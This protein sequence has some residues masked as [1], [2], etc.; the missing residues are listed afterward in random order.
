[1]NQLTP[2]VS[3][4]QAA[5]LLGGARPAFVAVHDRNRVQAARGPGSPPLFEVA[6]WPAAGQAYVTVVSNHPRLEPTSRIATIVD[7]L[8]LELDD[9][10][11]V[12]GSAGRLVVRRLGPLGSVTITNTSG[13]PRAVHVRRV[14]E[15]GASTMLKRSLEAGERWRL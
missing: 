2:L 3:A 6:R 4:Q 15:R 14:D 11:L 13:S 10:A 9:V 1:M 5:D 12:R 7:A 8:L